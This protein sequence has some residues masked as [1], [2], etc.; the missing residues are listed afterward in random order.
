M[1]APTPPSRRGQCLGP[2]ILGIL[3]LRSIEAWPVLEVPG[4]AG[5]SRALRTLV[6]SV[7]PWGFLRGSSSGVCKPRARSVPGLVFVQPSS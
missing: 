1:A 7:I 2:D 6:A 5:C 4:A 3:E